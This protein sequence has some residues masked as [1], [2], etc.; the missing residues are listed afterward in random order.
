LVA[1]R[2]VVLAVSR[3]LVNGE[4]D[5]YYAHSSL[6]VWE[7]LV[8]LDGTLSPA[9]QL[10][11]SWQLSSDQL[12]W[13]FQLQD[14]VSFT[15]GIPF[16]PASVVTN[17]QRYKKIDPRVSSF[18]T[19]SLVRAYGDL[20]EVRPEGS[21][22][23]VFQL[24]S[25][26]PSM[27]FTM[28]AFFSAMFSPASFAE[29]GDFKS[30]PAT[31]APFKLMD[32][33]KDQYA[34]LERNEAYRGKKP[35][36]KQIR[37]RVIPDSGAR[38]SAIRAGEV[39]GVVELG[40]LSPAEAKGLVGV[41]GITVAADPISISQY[42]AFNVGKAP[43]DNMSLRRA[44]AM[45]VDRQAIVDSLVLGYA[46]PGKSLFSP[47]APQWLSTKGL[48]AYDPAQARV[49]AQSALG[50]QR[51]KAQLLYRGGAGQ[52]RPWKQIA[53]L[54]QA[55]LAE[56]GIDV[57]LVGL[58]QAAMDDRTA[59]GEWSMRLAQQGWANGDP[60]FIMANFLGA[61]GAYN[62]DRG[63]A[64]R[65]PEVEQLVAAGKAEAD[66]KKRFAIYERLQE[67][68]VQDAPVTPLYH[69]HGAYAYRDTIGGLRQ[70]ITYQPTLDTLA[71][72]K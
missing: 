36:L 56:L 57:E 48:P 6:M 55:N 1:D 63:A 39:D 7:S 43:F 29:N 54:L 4:Q 25:P 40:A 67:I 60:D 66:Y 44:V 59:K 65:N 70:R 27:P 22:A 10:A 24:G 42:L 72:V 62:K 3:N 52:A 18:F 45:S 2:E 35:N 50:G 68:A 32:W 33:K 61:A 17:L 49:L 64:Y 69:E 12:T 26:N 28:S 46:T 14:G 5:P 31:T 38:V 37:V 19:F 53:E 34:L 11:K 23:I 8:T 51:V 71:L 58:E 16:D 47:F 21:N 9:P 15:D 30:I 20:K 13:T 41:K